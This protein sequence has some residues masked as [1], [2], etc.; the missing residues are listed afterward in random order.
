MKIKLRPEPPSESGP[1]EWS[2]MNDWLAHPK[3]MA[4]EEQATPPAPP[5][6]PEPHAW[7]EARDEVQPLSAAVPEDDGAVAPPAYD[8]AEPPADAAPPAA[9]SW[10]DNGSAPAPGSHQ[11]YG[12][13]E[14][15]GAPVLAADNEAG[16]A[17]PPG[18][19]PSVAP[20]AHA[21]GAY[22]ILGSSGAYPITGSYGVPEA[23]LAS[24]FDVAGAGAEPEP[25]GAPSEMA[26]D[27]L[28]D[29]AA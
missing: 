29:P 3:A 21:S 20:D 11:A 25:Y 8:A 19:A 22:P 6:P 24:G 26:A 9:P 7:G 14:T 16:V 2:E 28:D 4:D 12:I 15:Y 18:P 10:T 13:G 23:A 17:T 27:L 1:T 5:H